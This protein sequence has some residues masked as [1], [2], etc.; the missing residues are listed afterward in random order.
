MRAKYASSVSEVFPKAIYDGVLN[1]IDKA[2]F[3]EGLLKMKTPLTSPSA[4]LFIL[5]CLFVPSL[6]FFQ[7]KPTLSIRFVLNLEPSL[8][9]SDNILV[10]YSRRNFS[11]VV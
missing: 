4:R 10:V 6:T 8:T 11:K 7:V 1:R 5:H 2:S 3:N 9:T